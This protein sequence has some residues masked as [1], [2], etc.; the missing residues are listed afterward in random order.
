MGA[1][2]RRPFS[3]V[4]GSSR[5]RVAR[6]E[7]SH[8]P[9][10]E[11]RHHHQPRTVRH[12]GRRHREIV[13]P[14]PRHRP[15]DDDAVERAECHVAGE[16][17]IMVQPRDRGVA[18]NELRRYSSLPSEMLLEYGGCRKGD[19]GEA[20]RKRVTGIVAAVQNDGAITT[21][22]NLDQLRDAF[23]WDGCLDEVHPH[24]PHAGLIAGAS[25]DVG[26][27]GHADD[28]RARPEHLPG[29]KKASA[30]S[31]PTSRSLISSSAG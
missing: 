21:D 26:R 28:E 4:G 14:A 17:T 10:S 29:A 18:G 23:R 24:V 19:R 25:H 30:K 22:G 20:G 9:R 15:A 16:M 13:S 3:L 8:R 1:P 7:P 12:D 6:N 5:V 27:R 2:G 11:V 31:D